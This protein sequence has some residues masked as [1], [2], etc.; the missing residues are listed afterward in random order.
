V[1][2][3]L[4]RTHQSQVGARSRVGTPRTRASGGDSVSTH[5]RVSAT[6]GE[7][8]GR[9]TD[10]RGASVGGGDQGPIA[11][12]WAWAVL[13]GY[14]VRERAGVRAA[15]QP[16]VQGASHAATRADRRTDAAGHTS[17][18]PAHRTPTTRSHTPTAP[19]T[20]RG[21]R[22]AVNGP[23][24]GRGCGSSTSVPP[25]PHRTFL[26]R[27]GRRGPLAGR[28]VVVPRDSVPASAHRRTGAG[29][30]RTY[31]SPQ[32]SDKSP[33]QGIG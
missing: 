3:G 27:G 28:P 15:G 24:H 12:A 7:C 13:P 23:T 30:A 32:Q 6:R 1:R 11:P 22:R 29:R 33:V 21:A 4:D 18:L 10:L 31:S 2:P 9:V 5:D 16:Y 20:E 19:G 26:S 17:P 14:P 25:Q 8:P